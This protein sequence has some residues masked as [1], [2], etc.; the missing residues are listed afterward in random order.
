LQV[1][2]VRRHKTDDYR[3]TYRLWFWT[4]AWLVLASMEATACLRLLVRSTAVHFSGS[5]LAGGGDL[6]WMLIFGL[7]SLVLGV[8][9]AIEMRKSK[10]A[11]TFAFA[12]GVA[13]LYAAI[14][15]LGYVPVEEHLVVLHRWAAA[16][17][18]HSLVLA[19]IAI[20]ARR[21]L[22]DAQDI[23]H[24][25]AKAKKQRRQRSQK[26]TVSSEPEQDT[27]EKSDRRSS[28]TTKKKSIK[29]PTANTPAAKKKKVTSQDPPNATS[30]KRGKTAAKQSTPTKSVAEKADDKTQKQDGNSDEQAS[31]KQSK[32]Q[33]RREQAAQ[34]K[35]QSD[36]QQTVKKKVQA[37]K[38]SAQQ[39]TTR[40]ATPDKIVAKSV[41]ATPD[42]QEIEDEQPNFPRLSKSERR[43]MR[44]QRRNETRRAA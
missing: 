6:W 23:A 37:S 28:S 38:T 35:S 7:P 11:V 14:F 29:S 17:T 34:S 40:S 12:A 20:Y 22:L 2:N 32:R 43:K 5:E 9:L 44:K 15:Q 13:Y 21:V 3:G 33:K 8:R 4:A 1:Y 39:T 31:R 25:A 42:F 24:T 27:Q 18:A 26:Q 36:Q 30:S 10:A 16:L 19:T 41:E